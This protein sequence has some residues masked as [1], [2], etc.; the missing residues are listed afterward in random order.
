MTNSIRKKKQDHAAVAKCFCLYNKKGC[1][2]QK[3]GFL[4]WSKSEFK[5]KF[6]KQEKREK[7]LFET[8]NLVKN[9]QISLKKC[10][11]TSQKIIFF[12]VQLKDK[13]MSGF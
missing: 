3:K 7:L 4:T 1:R 10:M 2:L 12:S 6:L 8:W 13:Q 11:L 9:Y 5:S